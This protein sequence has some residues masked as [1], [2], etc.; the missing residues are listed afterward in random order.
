M[1][2][3]RDNS[4]SQYELREYCGALGIYSFSGEQV[5]HDIYLGLMN[6]QHR[7][8][9]SAG[10]ATSDGKKISLVRELGYVAQV[11]DEKT[12]KTL[13]GFVGIGHVRYPTI[14]AGGKEDAQ[15]FMQEAKGRT[16]AVAHRIISSRQKE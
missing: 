4:T 6:L 12:L 14:G 15:P 3:S 2:A 7:G 9:D 16:F 11:L 5:A 13:P 10:A 1:G 8:Q